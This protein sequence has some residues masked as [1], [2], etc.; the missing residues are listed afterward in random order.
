MVIVTRPGERSGATTGSEGGSRRPGEL[1]ARRRRWPCSRGDSSASCWVSP[2]TLGTKL[3]VS[4]PAPA[5]TRCSRRPGAGAGQKVGNARIP[6]EQAEVWAALVTRISAAESSEG[7]CA[8]A[9]YKKQRVYLR[10]LESETVYLI[11]TLIFHEIKVLLEETRVSLPSLPSLF[12]L[13][14]PPSLLLPVFSPKP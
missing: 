1:A 2:P 9:R 14:F 13:V 3:P 11:L 4:C 10:L 8:G 12:S 5:P 7:S 6:Y